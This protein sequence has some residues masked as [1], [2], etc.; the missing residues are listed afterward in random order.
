MIFA[1]F[2]SRLFPLDEP[3]SNVKAVH[4]GQSIAALRIE[5][6]QMRRINAKAQPF[7]DCNDIPSVQERTDVKLSAAV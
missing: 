5:E 1:S 6:M 4:S 7:A 2:E 3:R